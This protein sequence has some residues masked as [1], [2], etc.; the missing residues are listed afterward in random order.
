[1]MNKVEITF[2]I[3]QISKGKLWIDDHIT[4]SV[5]F[6]DTSECERV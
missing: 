5:R 4:N 2:S 1:M 6:L 3:S